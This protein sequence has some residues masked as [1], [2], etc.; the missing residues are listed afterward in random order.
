MALARK[1]I[2]DTFK[3][4]PDKLNHLEQAIQAVLGQPYQ[5]HFKQV[6]H[7]PKAIQAAPTLEQRG[8]APIPS[9]PVLQIPD[10]PPLK[11]TPFD[12]EEPEPLESLLPQTMPLLSQPLEKIIAETVALAASNPT[13]IDVATPPIKLASTEA[14][15]ELQQAKK[16]TQELLQG[17]LLD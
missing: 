12:N 6:E 11:T 3:R 8:P 2:F 4:T 14:E 13:Q 7:A 16:Y 10:A 5:L 9:S 17:K 15:Q 1:P